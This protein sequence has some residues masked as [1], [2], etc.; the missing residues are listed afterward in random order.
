MI[1]RIVPAVLGPVI[2]AAVGINQRA[3]QLG[4]DGVVGHG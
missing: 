4:P 2:R 3:G 1:E